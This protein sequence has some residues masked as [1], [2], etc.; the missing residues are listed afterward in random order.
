VPGRPSGRHVGVALAL[1]AAAALAVMGCEPTLHQARGIV[2]SVD[3]PALGRV[4]RFELLTSDGEHL[5]F[6]TSSLPFRQEFPAAHL[7][8]HRIL[9]DR[10]VVTYKREDDRLVVTQLDDDVGGPGHATPAEPS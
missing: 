5:V 6:D 4:D 7:S 8:E 3:S 1:F 2:L 9:G 10:I